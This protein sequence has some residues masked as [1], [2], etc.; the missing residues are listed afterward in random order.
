MRLFV[1]IVP[2]LEALMHLG[3]AIADV[4]A[5]VD[6]S[7]TWTTQEQWHLTLAFLGEVDDLRR[8]RVQ[9][10]LAR[11]A[12]RSPPLH[13]AIASAGVFGSRQRP[14][15]L[16]AG[17]DGD[18]AALIRL[19]QSTGAAARRSG[20]PV[21]ERRYRPHVTLAR[22]RHQVDVGPVLDNLSS[23]VG[24]SWTGERLH[25]VRSHLGQGAGRRARYESL[26]SWPL[27]AGRPDEG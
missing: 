6:D 17:V 10:R 5:L 9:T 20:I 26:V 18:V 25:L 23:Y 7:L 14:R 24:P 4:R 8:D 13:L 16:W 27:A 3:A 22:C 15:V 19:A 1:A 12:S 2:P 21:E 11:A